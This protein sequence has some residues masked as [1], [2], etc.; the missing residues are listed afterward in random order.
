V[1]CVFCLLKRDSVARL[2]EIDRCHEPPRHATLPVPL[3]S[4]IMP[5]TTWADTKCGKSLS[6]LFDLSRCPDVCTAKHEGK[7]IGS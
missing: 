7:I 5:S 6:H 4:I 1:G 2:T 3:K